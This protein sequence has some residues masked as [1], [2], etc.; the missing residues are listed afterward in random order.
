MEKVCLLITIY[1]L[2]IL[3]VPKHPSN[4]FI[5]CDS[6][7][8]FGGELGTSTIRCFLIFVESARAKINDHIETI[9][10]LSSTNVNLIVYKEPFVNGFKLH[11]GC[12]SRGHEYFGLNLNVSLGNLNLC[13]VILKNLSLI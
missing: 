13:V 11:L 1:C 4:Q 3:L 12:F 7:S 5:R 10:D 8:R 9:L 2:A 6:Q